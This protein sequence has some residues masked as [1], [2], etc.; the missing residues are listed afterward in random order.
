MCD[1]SSGPLRPS[2]Q[3]NSC[4][5]RLRSRAGSL[6]PTSAPTS[7]SPGPWRC[8]FFQRS[9]LPPTG[10][11]TLWLLALGARF[12]PLECCQSCCE[13]YANS[14]QSGRGIQSCSVTGGCSDNAKIWIPLDAAGET[15]CVR[16]YEIA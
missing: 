12:R 15:L 9:L 14:R 5:R 7:S 13:Q 6:S 4:S 16:H 8:N 10:A 1:L 3:L 2:C 11:S